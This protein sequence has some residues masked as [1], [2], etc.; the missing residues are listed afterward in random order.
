MNHGEAAD[1]ARLF[2]NWLIGREATHSDKL[3]SGPIPADLDKLLFHWPV[4]YDREMFARNFEKL[5]R[6]R[7]DTRRLAAT[8]LWELSREI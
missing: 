5:I 1:W 8:V 7:E 4:S 2:E 6:F 3:S